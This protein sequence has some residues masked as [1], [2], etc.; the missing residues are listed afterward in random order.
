MQRYLVMS[1]VLVLLAAVASA[2]AWQS[3]EE[4][5]ELVGVL[6]HAK[7]NPDI[8]EATEVE[9]PAADDARQVADGG[10]R[11]PIES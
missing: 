11:Q 7:P 5:P 1:F 4:M 6:K 10:L 3:P 2:Y 9:E 8:F